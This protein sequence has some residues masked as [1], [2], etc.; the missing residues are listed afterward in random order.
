MSDPSLVL[1]RRGDAGVT[2]ALATDNVPVSMFWPIWQVVARAGFCEI[3]CNG[4]RCHVV[5]VDQDRAVRFLEIADHIGT[6]R[7]A[8][9]NLVGGVPRRRT[10]LLAGR[11]PART[12]SLRRGARRRGRP[13]HRYH[14]AALQCA[15]PR[16][17]IRWR[18]MDR[19]R[20]DGLFLQFRGRPALSAGARRVRAA[21]AHARARRGVGGSGATPTA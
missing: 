5:P 11:T 1:A 7:R 9:H 12:G 8:I 20:R 21:G 16:A 6:H 14:S 19:A 17:R 15:H 13:T 18:I 10:G 3:P 4:Q 2:V